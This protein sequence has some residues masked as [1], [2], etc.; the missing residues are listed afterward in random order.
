MNRRGFLKGAAA[1]VAGLATAD[2]L[3]D[4]EIP[5]GQSGCVEPPQGNYQAELED[6]GE[7]VT[8]RT[9]PDI[10][11]FKV[12]QRCSLEDRCFLEKM[13]RLDH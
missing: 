8:I 2:V 13:A 5:R 10:Y 3:A 6:R 11:P 9:T 7:F 4:V 1:A 12:Q